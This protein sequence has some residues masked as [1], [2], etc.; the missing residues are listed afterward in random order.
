M[1]KD[2]IPDAWED[3]DWETQAD[4]AE[5]EPEPEPEPSAPVP[6][7]HQERLAKHAE[8]QRKLW[9]SAYELENTYLCNGPSDLLTEKPR[10]SQTSSWQPQAP[11]PLQPPSNP[12]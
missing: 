2:K 3:D 1:P 7:T 6:M 4:R 11:F 12:Q 5:N 9:E 10:Q 8:E